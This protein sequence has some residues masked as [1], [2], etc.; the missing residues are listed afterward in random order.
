MSHLEW[1]RECYLSIIFNTHSPCFSVPAVN[2]SSVQVDLALS[3]LDGDEV[4]EDGD[5]E[6]AEGAALFDDD[7][8]VFL[9]RPQIG[10]ES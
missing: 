3:S 5:G 9:H 10:P 8:I 1:W 4:E 7:R 6:D 2:P